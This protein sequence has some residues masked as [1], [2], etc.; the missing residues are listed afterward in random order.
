MKPFLLFCFLL[1]I[2]SASAQLQFAL[3]PYYQPAAA[4]E[5]ALKNHL[6]SIIQSTWLPGDSSPVLLSCTE[7]SFNRNGILIKTASTSVFSSTKAITLY[8]NEGREIESA[9]Y[10]LDSTGLFYTPVSIERIAYVLQV[11]GAD[12]LITD[13]MYNLSVSTSYQIT[14]QFSYT[15]NCVYETGSLSPQK[16]FRHKV[17]QVKDGWAVIANTF[18]GMS[19]DISFDTL[20][21]GYQNP[22]SPY[23]LALLDTTCYEKRADSVWVEYR[24]NQMDVSYTRLYKSNKLLWSLAI[25]DPDSQTEAIYEYNC[26][27][28][29][30]K[31]TFYNTG[32]GIRTL[33]SY[34]LY[35]YACY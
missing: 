3:P 27:G 14:Y 8:N 6:S 31:E 10:T 20:L 9:S 15:E 18:C 23:Y 5:T 17:V 13:S 22:A 11:D 30:E 21:V 4:N 19:R 32:P 1:S 28:L 7:D 34:N 16:C 26:A 2:L 35:K 33:R 24:D 29:L 12:S 25:I